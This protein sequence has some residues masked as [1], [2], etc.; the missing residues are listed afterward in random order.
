MDRHILSPWSRAIIPGLLLL[1][2]LLLLHC[3]LLSYKAAPCL[4][5]LPNNGAAGEAAGLQRPHLGPVFVRDDL[6]I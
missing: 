4:P 5:G 3:C 6:P 1:L 2:L